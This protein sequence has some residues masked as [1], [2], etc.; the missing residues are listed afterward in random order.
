MKQKNKAI[1]IAVLLFVTLC[2]ACG[3][4]NAEDPY[5]IND[6]EN[7]TLSVKYDA[8][9]GTFTT[10]TYVIVDSYDLTQMKTDG[11]G[12]AQIALLSPDAAARGKN[13]F[14]AVNNGYFLAGWYTERTQTGVDSS[15][16]PLYTY[17]CR[18]TGADLICGVDPGFSN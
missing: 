8:N 15:G 16:M 12:M 9:G 5:Q 7:Y 4:S 10:N 6:A 18:G 13:A 3:C 17:S 14:T 2:F 11:N 1:C